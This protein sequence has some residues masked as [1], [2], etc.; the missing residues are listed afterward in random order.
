MRSNLRKAV[1]L[2]A[3]FICAA[4]VIIGYFCMKAKKEAVQSISAGDRYDASAEIEAA[5]EQLEDYT[6]KA[7]IITGVQTAQEVIALN[8]KGMSSNK[9]N[10]EILK[11]LKQYGIK[12]TFFLP[13][14]RAAED[15]AVVAEMAED[16]HRVESNTLTGS[17]NLEK[18]SK[19][20][21]IS[22]FIRTNTILKELTKRAPE[23]LMCNGTEY[24]GEL[25]EA[26]SLS[27]YT[28][29]VTGGNYLSYQSFQSYEQVQAYV[30][31]LNPG[32]II[33]I[34]LNGPLD[35]YEYAKEENDEKQAIDKQ[36]EDGT[37]EE[38][39]SVLSEKE[40]LMLIRVVGWLLQAV[41]EAG[42]TTVFTADLADYADED[43]IKDFSSYR[44]MNQ[45]KLAE[46]YTRITTDQGMLSLSFRGI[47]STESLNQIL[48]FLKEKDCRATFFVTSEDL[49]H[50]GDSIRK[51][52]DQ[53]HQI[54][55]GGWSGTDIT[56]GS[57]NN[58]CFEIYKCNKLLKE[59]YGVTS[60]IFMPAYGKYNDLVRE[61]ASALGVKLVTYSKNPVTDSGMSLQEI[62]DYYKN[63][64]RE[65]DVIYFRL[66]Y[67]R[68][69]LQAVSDTYD[70][71]QG[72]AFHF[73]SLRSL[74]D[75]HFIMLADDQSKDKLIQQLRVK[76]AGRLATQTNMVYT[77]Q[78]ALSYTFT[79][80]S[81]QEVVSDVLDKLDTLGAKGTFF[82]TGEETVRYSA[83]IKKISDA[84][85]EIE[86][87]L[88][89]EE[90][91]DFATVAKKILTIQKAVHKICGQ[92][93]TLVRCAYLIN[94]PEEMLEAISSTGCRVIWQKISFV[95]S[96]AGKQGTFKEVKNYIYNK[97]NISAER[98]SIIFFRLD[99]YDDPSLVGKLIV[100]YTKSRVA[101]IS[102][103]D[104]G[105]AVSEYH[106]VPL[107]ELINGK[108][109][110]TYPV[111]SDRILPAL[112]DKIYSGHLANLNAEGLL[113]TLSE[114]Y[115]G[116]PDISAS[117]TLPGF[118]EEELERL[119]KS[120][121]F[122]EDKV[123][124][125]TFDDWGSDKPVNQ[126]LYV[127]KKYNVKASFFVRTNHIEGNPNLLRAIAEEGH[128]IASH[129]DQHL[130][131]ANYISGTAED[132]SSMEGDVTSVYTNIT[133]KEA[134]EQRKDIKLSYEKLES[135]IGDVLV[136]GRP[137]LTTFFR[138]PTLAMS[139]RGMEA[140]L[141]MG[142]S[143]IISGD[144][145]THDY[146]EASS[147]TL[148]DTLQNGVVNEEGSTHT[149]QNGSIVVLHM[150]DDTDTPNQ[151]NDLTAEALDIAIP[152]L[153]K[154]GYH[155][156]RLSDYLTD[157]LN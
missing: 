24:T 96:S 148:A 62:K 55:N 105:K 95:S 79:G 117:T 115:I 122:T 89:P 67:Y 120:G 63:G 84:G 54:A 101:S 23:L 47:G 141:D 65:G 111:I 41:N 15:S 121:V 40:Q 28:A 99:F 130:P 14:T 3:I 66:D 49:L 73:A 50:N 123:I 133:E 91:E 132:G 118:S 7:D 114:R 116:N 125:L 126:I 119:D 37:K 36:P 2:V 58:I 13:G 52:L 106:I 129:T 128:D 139:K 103:K 4:A 137:A 43:F 48:E 78:K 157:T 75:N 22:D 98:G 76:N 136:D 83:V 112:K 70:L 102:Y 1:I 9:T 108:K 155:F 77:T 61:A 152:K 124:F 56:S 45:G 38:D 82:V 86:I 104:N 144:F 150:S 42:R 32:S 60:D 90:G 110:Y 147:K 143:Y 156:A 39:G 93:P 94:M 51:I 153:L 92:T 97:G 149:L 17:K 113:N 6:D 21:L 29:V 146:E 68:D 5:M 151:S 12:S 53:G 145:S 10:L 25:L 26:A 142:F 80:I 140:I 154:Q 109:A 87:C 35:G 57:F 100:N 81:N 88:N 18:E 127:L 46:V 71:A 31:S 59:S 138:P 72:Q 8:F 44:E 64:F 69:I 16:G 34:K 134:D 107:R 19:E 20:E 33:T 135:V 27:G 85:H 74:F 11:L 131:F 30:N